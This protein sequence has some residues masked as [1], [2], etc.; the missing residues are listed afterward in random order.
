MLKPGIRVAST[1]DS[2]SISALVSEQSVKH[3]IHEFTPDGADHLLASMSPDSIRK[4]IQ[5]GY[6]YHVAEMD[7]RIIGVVGVKDNSHLYH[8]FVAEKFRRQGVARELWQVSMT[9]CL[10]RGNPGEFTVNSSRYAL[11]VYKK[12]GFV[13]QS[14]PQ[15]KNGVVFIPM[16]LKE[17]P[18][19]KKR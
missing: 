1:D 9:S 11:G 8:L 3:I 16:K 7:G 5:S 19:Q 4:Y 18:C 2:E 13:A 6:F 15:E 14:G 10:S 12:L 17:L